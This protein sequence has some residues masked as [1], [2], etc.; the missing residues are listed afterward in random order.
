MVFKLIILNIFFSSLVISAPVD[1]DNARKV[2]ANIYKERSNTGLLDGFNIRS[3][4][5]IE[6]NDANLIYIFQIDSDGFIMVSGEDRIQPLLAY[7]FESNLVLDDMPSNLSWM[8]DAYKG[9]INNAI[10]SNESSTEKIN[11]EWRKYYSG[12]D[13]NIRDRDMKGPLFTSHWNQSSGWNDYGPPADQSCEG[14]Q[15]PSG[16][17]AVSMASIMHYWQYPITGQGDNSCYCG[18]YGTQ[19]ANFGDAVYDYAAMGTAETASDA[20]AF[21]VWH[22]GVAVNM[23]YDCPGS[24]AQVSGGYPSALYAME[25]NFLYKD[26]IYTSYRSSSSDSQWINY[27]A[28]SYT[29]LRAHET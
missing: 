23:D 1:L 21:L 11:A 4:D 18:G 17:V 22:A 7:S 3:I 14:D 5:V 15:A 6:E 16:C 12:E 10:V 26:N 24:G 27:L 13:L 25:N 8:I 9:M 19:Y 20:A 28:V 2:A 29:H